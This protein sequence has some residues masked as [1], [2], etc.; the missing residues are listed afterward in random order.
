MNFNS[1]LGSQLL[2]PG[3]R[4]HLPEATAAIERTGAK[5]DFLGLYSRQFDQQLSRR[6]HHHWRRLTGRQYR[7]ERF[8]I[9]LGAHKPTE[10]VLQDY[11]DF[12]RSDHT[13]FWFA[14][15]KDY[16]ASFQGILLADTGEILAHVV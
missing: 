1:S 8:D 3:Y 13:R 9:S 16:Y 5:G 11:A 4:T 10:E 6:F 2:P 14:N 7:L 12:L 15:T